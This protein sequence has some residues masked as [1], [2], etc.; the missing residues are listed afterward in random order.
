MTN[1]AKK[2]TVF[3]NVCSIA[4]AIIFVLYAG[5]LFAGRWHGDE[6]HVL[7]DVR[8]YGFSILIDRVI[9][10]S[11]RPI[12]E[13]V[14]AGYFYAVIS[15]GYRLIT[16]FLF[17][18]WCVFLM[19]PLAAAW[20]NREDGNT[21]LFMVLALLALVISGGNNSDILYWTQGAVAYIPTF[22][23]CIYFS[24]R[25]ISASEI[26]YMDAFLL[27]ILSLS[28][29]AGTFVV[30]PFVTLSILWSAF[31]RSKLNYGGIAALVCSLIVLFLALKGRVS[32]SNEAVNDL[33][34]AHNVIASL[35]ATTFHFAKEFFV[36]GD[37]VVNEE[38]KWFGILAKFMFFVGVVLLFRT[39]KMSFQQIINSLFW[40][41]SCLAASIMMI[42][43]SF[44]KLGIAGAPRHISTESMF[45]W[46]SLFSLAVVTSQF[47]R[48]LAFLGSLKRNIGVVLV[49]FAAILPT[50]LCANSISEDYKNLNHYA[51][52]RDRI[53]YEG[54]VSGETMNVSLC[55][56]GKIVG[57]FCDYFVVGEYYR[58]DGKSWITE[59]IMRY[60]QKN[61][62]VVNAPND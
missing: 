24:V 41:I 16:A 11:P 10:W 20:Q 59:A 58:G 34:I 45:M 9:Y 36:F 6:F 60:F 43:S 7:S 5:L 32:V 54:K 3:L 53:L 56:P 33:G 40:S 12:S 49:T 50:V 52:Q 51:E 8:D 57:N 28:S 4:L 46:L 13:L 47:S 2:N 30:L 35:K 26:K 39:I 37:N 42:F 1:C 31:R 14:L 27:C 48:V 38:M 25:L 62:L 29:E 17:I 61:H 44:Y 21:A 55:H 15:S 23:L 19:V 22:A 18:L